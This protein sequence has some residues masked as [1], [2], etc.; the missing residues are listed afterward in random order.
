[1]LQESLIP[2]VKMARGEDT[3]DHIHIFDEGSG[4]SGTKGIDRRKKLRSMMD[5]IVDDQIGDVVCARPDRLFR[6]K[7]FANVSTFTELAERMRVK[8]VIPTERGVIVYDFSD[9]KSL[10]AFQQ[11]MQQ[12]YAYIDT[13]I[14]YMNRARAFKVS[15]GFY[16]GG[17]IPLPYVLLRDM[18]KEEQVRVIY[19]PWKEAAEDLFEKFTQFHFE[20]GRLARYI[21]DKPYIFKYMSAEHL[22]EYQIVTTMA[23]GNGGY[24]FARM[25]TMRYYL[26]NFTLAGFTRAG[27]DPDTGDTIL[28]PNAFDAAVPLELFE[29]C[30]AAI[31]GAYLDGTPFEKNGGRRQFRGASVEIDALLHGLL[32]SNEGA[33][34]CFANAAEDYPVYELRRDSFVDAYAKV[35][36][37]R[38]DVLWALPARP[39]DKIILDRLIALAEYDSE[40]VERVKQ[41]FAEAVKEGEN[42]LVVLDTAIRN[43]QEAIQRV[44]KTIVLLTK[45]N[46]DDEGK[47][48]ELDENDPIVI[49]RRHLQVTLRRLQKQREEAARQTK[50]DPAHS[51]TN[52]YHVLSHLRTEFT[53]QS[54]QRKKDFIRKLIEEVKITA[55]SPHLFTLYIT[56][57]QPLATERDDVALLWRCTPTKSDT[58]S[59]WTKEEEAALR[60]LYP[61]R[62]QL[63]IMKSIPNK[64]PGMI[65]N[66][67]YHLHVRRQ[68]NMRGGERFFWTVCYADLQAAAQF[69][70]TTIEK[71]FLFSQINRMA[72]ETKKGNISALWFFPVD[73][74]SFAKSLNVTDILKDGLSGQGKQ[75]T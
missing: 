40:L 70:E 33:I 26:S 21:E 15:K 66:R 35:G 42:S 17:C 13:Q 24:T 3:L 39:I 30:F 5:E 56:W 47:E 8:V 45:G 11:E 48:I 64:T 61:L 7:H 6:D 73:M 31:T 10:Q 25:K 34:N 53:K 4:V 19:E 69:T 65:K 62:P 43:T 60:T 27:K 54:P 63:E 68:R 52:F 58:V 37:G 74:V 44:S 20:T 23:K 46:V 12:A 57:I 22:E 41:F 32:T 49:E 36:L 29:P 38:V 9:V 16:G 59:V 72:E 2:F 55:I 51:I 14:G 50:E 18:P 1:M 75:A 67:A 71:D 28:I